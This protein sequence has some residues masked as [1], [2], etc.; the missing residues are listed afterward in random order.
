MISA[1]LLTG[2]LLLSALAGSASVVVTRYYHGDGTCPSCCSNVTRASLLARAVS[3][4]SPAEAPAPVELKTIKLAKLLEELK[5]HS[6]K[7]VV[8]DLWA[9]FCVPCKKGF[10]HLVEMHQ[11]HAKDGLVCISVSVDELKNQEAALKFLKKQ[12]AAF[13]NYLL[14]DR[15]EVWQEHWNIVAIPAVFLYRDGAKIA[16]FDYEDPDKQFTYDDVEQA[17]VK[18]LVK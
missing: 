11:R 6:G 5:G 4:E 12:Q 18:N 16:Q 13:P 15:A 7:L 14:E 9:D 2:L 8:V 3:S 17:V 10:P 1:K